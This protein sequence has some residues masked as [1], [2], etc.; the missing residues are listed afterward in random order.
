MQWKIP[1]RIVIFLVGAGRDVATKV[2]A[3]VALR[4]YGMG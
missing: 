1:G 4:Q 3:K 2:I